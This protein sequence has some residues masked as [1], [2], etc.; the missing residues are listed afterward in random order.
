MCKAFIASL[1]IEL[2]NIELLTNSLCLKH[3]SG[4]DHPERPSRI[5][6]IINSYKKESSLI[7][8]YNLTT[9]EL[10]NDEKLFDLITQVHSKYLINQL[11]SS[12]KKNQTFFNFDCIANKHTYFAALSSAKLTSIAAEL[13]TVNKSNFAV[14]R[15]PGHHATYS[16]MRGFCYINNIA[17]ATTNLISKRKKVAII[18]FD[19]HYGNGTANIFYENPDVLYISIHA[20][21]AINYPNSGFFN[22]IGEGEGMGLNICI[23]L[24][25]GS[26]DNELVG[27]FIQIILPLLVEFGPDVI[28]VSAGFDG[29]FNDPVG[30]GFLMYTNRGYNKVGQIIH[31]YSETNRTPVFHVLEGGYDI[32][33]LPKLID[34]YILPWK[35]QRNKNFSTKSYYQLS[36]KEKLKKKERDMFLNIKKFLKPFWDI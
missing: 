7:Q 16:D 29:Y 34:N 9:N 35:K 21:P 23:P 1:V 8:E 26:G 30:L 4:F 6:N 31:D 18:D 27:S 24:S 10:K 19:Y 15:P 13:S 36:G 14:I 11:E 20:D 17:V 12:Q 5:K 28:G 22:E 32:F 3:N 25:F 33:R 2:T